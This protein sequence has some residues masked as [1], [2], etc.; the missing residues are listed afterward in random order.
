MAYQLKTTG[1]AANCTMCIAV[2]PDT[3]TIK[4]FAS[5]TVTADITV[6]AGITIGSG[7]WDGNT[8]KYFQL[9]TGNYVGFGTNKP[10]FSFNTTNT[11]RTVVWIGENAGAGTLI[12]GNDSGNY[13]GAN[14]IVGGGDSFPTANIG[15]STQHGALVRPAAGEKWIFG[16]SLVRSTSTIAYTAKHDA[17]AMTVQTLSAIS[18]SVSYTLDFVGRRDDS[19]SQIADKIH[20]VLIFDTDLTEAQWDTLRDDWFGTLLEAVVVP[21]TLSGT[22]TLGDI[23]ASGDLAPQPDSSL[24]GSATLGDIT[25]SGTL[26]VAPG[27][28]TTPVLKNN[29]GTILAS[30]SGVVANVYHPTTGALVVRKTGLSSDGSGIVTITDALLVPGTSYVYEIDLSAASLGRRLPVGVAA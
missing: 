25:A 4:D 21:A 23:T 26:G 13:F 12:F 15:S 8:R 14:W 10:T 9:A 24:S 2:D 27:V 7:T 29:T 22:A 30:V 16:F 19:T 28:I 5:S 3:N 17:S 18:S 6:D 11:P 1:I 20:A